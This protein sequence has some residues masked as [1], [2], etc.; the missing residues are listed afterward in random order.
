MQYL[1]I[2]SCKSNVTAIVTIH[3]VNIWNT[4]LK[5][6]NYEI[7]WITQ[8]ST[9]LTSTI[10][11]LR[12][13]KTKLILSAALVSWPRS[14]TSRMGRWWGSLCPTGWDPSSRGSACTQNLVYM[15]IIDLSLC[16]H[17]KYPKLAYA[18]GL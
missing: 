6:G 4:Y 7:Y 11:V 9:S 8:I 1:T 17:F 14:L 12:I 16:R 13:N 3:K 18:E 15:D 2:I 5:A 10:K